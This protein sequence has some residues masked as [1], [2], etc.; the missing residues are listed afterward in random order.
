MVCRAKKDW[1]YSECS[2]ATGWPRSY[3]VAWLPLLVQ[4][5]VGSD[6]GA[7]A[8]QGF[9]WGQQRGEA[10]ARDRAAAGVAGEGGTD[11]SSEGRVGRKG[12]TWRVKFHVI[13]CKAHTFGFVLGKG[14]VERHPHQ[15]VRVLVSVCMKCRGRM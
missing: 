15:Y 12:D 7:L 11:R 10:Q 8:G 1:I 5:E 2:G 3:Q 14:T 6:L 9:H 4:K 13:A